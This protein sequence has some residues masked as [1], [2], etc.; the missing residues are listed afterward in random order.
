MFLVLSFDVHVFVLLLC[1]CSC[2]HVSALLCIQS[3]SHAGFSLPPECSDSAAH[4][5]L[6][7]NLDRAWPSSL[8][9]TAFIST[10]E[11]AFNGSLPDIASPF[12]LASAPRFSFGSAVLSDRLPSQSL[13][14]GRIDTIRSLLG[15]GS[16]A[17]LPSQWRIGIVPLLFISDPLPIA[18]QWQPLDRKCAIHRARHPQRHAT[19]CAMSSGAQ[20]SAPFLTTAKHVDCDWAVAYYGITEEHA[21]PLERLRFFFHLPRS[22]KS[23]LLVAVAGIASAYTTVLYMDEDIVIRFNS[24]VWDAELRCVFGHVPVV[25]RPTFQPPSQLIWPWMNADCFDDNVRALAVGNFSFLEPQIVFVRADF[26]TYFVDQY[27]VPVF[28]QFPKIRAI[29][30]LLATICFLAER[31]FPN[32]VPCAMTRAL[33]VEHA[34]LRTLSKH[35]R[36]LYD[37]QRITLVGVRHFPE[38]DY[39]GADLFQFVKNDA[40]CVSRQTIGADRFEPWTRPSRPATRPIGMRAVTQRQKAVEMLRQSCVHR[41]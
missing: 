15:M 25:W 5:A 21:L 3:P 2:P 7:L 27:I 14:L 29:W 6:A 20:P 37:S 9:I 11:C 13:A 31:S 38:G 16:S 39:V 34:D 17:T 40:P 18:L 22:L 26:F 35:G 1:L 41:V 32:A 8:S 23:D 30:T 36:H 19:L 28:V 33:T 4:P 12:A 24:T 10:L